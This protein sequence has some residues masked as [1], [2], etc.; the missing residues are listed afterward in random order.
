MSGRR[1]PRPSSRPT[2][3]RGS[4]DRRGRDVGV[5]GG[6]DAADPVEGPAGPAGDA[7]A[8]PDSPVGRRLEV[9]T[10][11]VAHGGH[12]VARHEGQVVF[13]RHAVPG[14]RVVVE[15]T[16]DSGRFL[17]ADAV[18]VLEAS[19]ARVTPPCPTPDPASAA[20][21]TSSTSTSPSSAG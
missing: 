20:A 9:E 11:A 2:G 15:V 8:D 16:E 5:A 21:A 10:G 19:P 1:G 14:E 12:V 4:A 7:A 3:G 18:E 13:V 6:P 17:R